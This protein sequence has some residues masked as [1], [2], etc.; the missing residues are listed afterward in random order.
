[1]QIVDLELYQHIKSGW[2]KIAVLP[3]CDDE[4]VECVQLR[5][6]LPKFSVRLVTRIF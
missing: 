3:N 1:M 4:L 6:R 2:R 5:Y